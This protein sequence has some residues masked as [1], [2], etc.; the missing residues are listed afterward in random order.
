MIAALVPAAGRSRRMGTQ[1]LLLPFGDTTIIARVVDE[2]LRSKIDQVHVVIS[3]QGHQI[4]AAL[5]GRDVS[6]VT[7]PDNE[8]DMLSSVRCGIRALPPECAAILLALG[9]QPGVTAELVNTIID[10][11]TTGR[12][13]ILVPVHGGR[14]GH[15]LLFSAGYRRE[16]LTEHDEVGL[17]GLLRAHG[18]HVFELPVSTTAVLSDVDY[19][20]DYQRERAA[21][22]RDDPTNG[23]SPGG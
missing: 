19:P 1:K 17:R 15:P 4:A 11:F 10:A 14:R 3:H 8:G 13:Q 20:E 2:L 5:S 9:D 21:L 7:N 23:I 22:E 16:I 18:N 6:F 12:H